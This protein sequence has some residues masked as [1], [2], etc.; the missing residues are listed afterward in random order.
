MLFTIGQG[1]AAFTNHSSPYLVLLAFSA[2]VAILANFISS[3]V[4][5]ALLFPV[6]ASVG[7]QTGHPKMLTVLCA[8]MTSGVSAQGSC[9]LLQGLFDLR[10]QQ[11]RTCGAQTPNAALYAHQLWANLPLRGAQKW[12]RLF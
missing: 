8:L 5:A 12:M 11:T 1:M 4:A 9:G 7:E 6:I 10:R 3:T 2:L